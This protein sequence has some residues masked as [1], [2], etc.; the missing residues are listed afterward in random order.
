MA[1][2]NIT[3]N[4]LLQ[5]NE[6]FEL[7]NWPIELG[8]NRLTLYQRFCERLRVFDSEEQ[9]LMIRLSRNFERV[10]IQ[11]YTEYFWLGYYNI[12]TEILES[13]DK[14]IFMPL[15][16]IQDTKKKNKT[17]SS[18]ALHYI[19]SSGDYD[20]VDY[21]NKFLFIEDAADLQRELKERTILIFI[22]DFLGSG[23]TARDTISSFIEKNINLTPVNTIILT[24]IAQ[25]QGVINVKTQTGCQVFSNQVYGRGISD[26]FEGHMID[27]SIA[28]MKEMERKIAPEIHKNGWSLGFEQTE[29]L[30]SMSAK[31]PNNTFPVFWYETKTKVSPFPRYKEFKYS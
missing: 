29:A 12:P 8:N 22:D 9:L 31:S 28:L 13:V 4:T 15:L 24:M 2:K 20:W 10:L 23:G 19:L 30:V 3:A 7:K 17:K 11:Q 25:K 26:T 1:I 16:K 14:I 6:L 27:S 21:S 18:S 5:I